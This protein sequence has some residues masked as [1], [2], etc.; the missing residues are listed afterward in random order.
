MKTKIYS[1][2]IILLLLVASFVAFFGTPAFAVGAG[3]YLD[4]DGTDDYVDL[5]NSSTLK[6]T[7]NLTI[8][9]W[10]YN[11]DWSSVDDMDLI[12]NTQGG[13]Y[14]I[15]A[16]NNNIESAI[17]LN[18]SYKAVT[19]STSGFRAG[20]HHVAVTASMLTFCKPL[21]YAPDV[22]DRSSITS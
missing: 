11:D 20:W 8:E 7:D 10:V 17:H 18:G 14:D 16:D 19:Y 12:S 2:N 6:P 15:E 4:F 9:S 13:G 5:G 21:R 1:S 22:R 3:N